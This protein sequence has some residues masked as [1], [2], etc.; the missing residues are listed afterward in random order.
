MNKT[1]EE[2][3]N[4]TQQKLTAQQVADTWTG[5]STFD[6]FSDEL[7]FVGNYLADNPADAIELAREDLA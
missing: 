4:E 3:W 2:L 1:H 6:V 7:G 5:Y